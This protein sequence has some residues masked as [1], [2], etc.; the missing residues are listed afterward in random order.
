MKLVIKNGRV[1]NP[2]KNIDKKMDILIE[3]GIIKQIA[4]LI[5]EE[6]G[7]KVLDAT[8]MII[9]PGF[10]DIHAHLREPGG[11]RAETIETGTWSAVNGGFTAVAAMP[12]TNP[13]MD[14]AAIVSLVREKAKRAGYAKV[15]PVG[16][17]SK[18]RES[19]ELANIGEMVGE[20]IIAIS[21]DGSAVATAEMIKKALEYCKPFGIPVMEHAEDH[22]LTKGAVINESY[23]S[24][25]LGLKGM[26]S[27]AEDIIVARDIMVNKQVGSWIHIAHLSSEYS[28]KII[29]DAKSRGEKVTCD[30]TPHH[31][32]LNDEVLNDFN[33]NHIMK[34]PLRKESDRIAMIE[35]IKDGT[36]DCIATDHAPHPLEFKNCEIDICAF[37]IIG[38]ETS[39]PIIIDLLH[40]KHKVPISRIVE[41]MAIN[42]SKI[43]G[44][45]ENRLKEGAV[46][47]L[48]I[49]SPNKEVVI[50]SSMFKSRARNTPFNGQKFMG[51]PEY[52]IMKDKVFTCK[53]G[54]YL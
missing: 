41:L 45:E 16:A 14:N 54:E 2:S 4:S 38:F 5:K 47:D 39:I 42:P 40:H 9:A 32:F 52:T 53:V 15:L 28:L 49:F 24:T 26:P 31:L 21:D 17:V 22:S 50:D 43:A 30:V 25:K 51:R 37:G 34:P 44:I 13:C 12:N 29:K 19:K 3:D 48:T 35:G 8:D 6:D 7:D 33:T 27:I 1:V 20:G 18:K 10:I 36:I 11:E 23:M 46:A